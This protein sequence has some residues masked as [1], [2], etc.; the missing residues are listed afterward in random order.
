MVVRPQETR[1]LHSRE[2]E[3]LCQTALFSAQQG[4]WPR[5]MLWLPS[6]F[7]PPQHNCRSI[8]SWTLTASWHSLLA[9]RP[10]HV[11]RVDRFSGALLFR[12]CQFGGP[13]SQ[14]SSQSSLI[15]Q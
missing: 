11:L 9:C 7:T 1:F 10:N 4:P 12:R 6:D 3:N 2:V 8:G 5:H 15:V 14:I 13:E